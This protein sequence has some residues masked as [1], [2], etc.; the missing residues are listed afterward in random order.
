MHPLRDFPPL[1]EHKVSNNFITAREV[2]KIIKSPD[3]KT[4]DSDKI[5]MVV[6]KEDKHKLSPIGSKTTQPLFEWEILPTSTAR[7]TADI[8]SLNTESVRH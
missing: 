8:L 1:T 4:T 6:L 2:S 3:F 7:S 5:P